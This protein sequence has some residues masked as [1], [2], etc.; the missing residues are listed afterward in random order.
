MFPLFHESAVCLMY[1]FTSM[2]F[3][4]T[5][6]DSYIEIYS[7]HLFALMYTYLDLNNKQTNKTKHILNLLVYMYI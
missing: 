1:V 4:F 7:V 6:I 5:S 3:T 2:S